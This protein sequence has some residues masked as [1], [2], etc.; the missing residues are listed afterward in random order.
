MTKRDTILNQ[1]VVLD[2]CHLLF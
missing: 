1:E 2:H